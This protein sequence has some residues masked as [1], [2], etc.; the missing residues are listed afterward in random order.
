MKKNEL[1]VKKIEDDLKQGL[2]GLYDKNEADH[3]IGLLFSHFTGWNRAEVKIRGEELL[4]GECADKL[5]AALEDLR[6]FKPVQ[7]I[8]GNTWFC[9]LELKVTPDALIP[10]P[11]TEELAEMV[12]RENIQFQLQEISIL[13]IGTGTGCL[14]LALKK[15]FPYGLVEAIDN[16]PAALAL[17]AENAAGNGLKIGF[18]KLDILDRTERDLLPGYQVIVS[19]PPYVTC[20]EK[21]LMKA[22][23]LNYEPHQA[24]FVPDDDPLLYY[25][26]IGDFAFKHLIRPGTLYVEINER[27]G[28]EVKK[29]FLGMGFDRAEVIKDLYGKDRFVR[30]E[31]VYVMADTSYW[32]VADNQIP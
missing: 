28:T 32:M 6:G 18:R 24:L 10:R 11:E 17:S 19:N 1:T 5:Y 3:L 13:D 22:N 4:S 2:A 14:A 15:K 26:A 7:Y 31:A 23:V 20:S 27:F 8:I 25:K 12:I 30:A 16:D 29:L 21:R 9:G